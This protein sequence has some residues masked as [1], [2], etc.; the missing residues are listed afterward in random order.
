M[1]AP[2]N[3]SERGWKIPTDSVTSAKGIVDLMSGGGDVGGMNWAETPAEKA[4]SVMQRKVGRLRIFNRD[5]GISE[6]ESVSF[7]AL[8]NFKACTRGG[9]RL[10]I[11][12]PDVGVRD[13]DRR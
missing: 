2:P 6:Q 1:V 13:D 4:R 12:N 9:E 7:D 8:H 5:G 3:C 11:R 10:F